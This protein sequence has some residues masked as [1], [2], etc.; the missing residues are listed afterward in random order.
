MGAALGARGFFHLGRSLRGPWRPGAGTGAALALFAGL[1]LLARGEWWVGG[2]LLAAAAGLAFAARRRP[3]LRARPIRPGLSR[4][5]AAALLGVAETAPAAEVE[6][7]HRRLIRR[8]HPDAGGTAA[9]AAQL[10]A[11]REVM[12]RG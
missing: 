11:A 12:L 2:A 3:A 6:A 5:E 10:N 7:A 1:A 8:I 9:L 4:R